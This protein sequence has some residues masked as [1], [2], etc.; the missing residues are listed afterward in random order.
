M[1]SARRIWRR[2]PPPRSRPVAQQQLETRR[3]ARARSE[4]HVINASRCTNA[5]AVIKNSFSHVLKRRRRECDL[6]RNRRRRVRESTQ[7]R[8][9]AISDNIWGQLSH[10]TDNTKTCFPNFL[11]C[12]YSPGAVK[13]HSGIGETVCNAC[14]VP[15]NLKQIY[16]PSADTCHARGNVC[17]Y[18]KYLAGVILP[19]SGFVAGQR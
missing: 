17:R 2:R 18:L 1:T 10:S 8:L 5:G 9:A 7:S 4:L 16:F 14:T 12:F 13:L 19:S 15:L 6:F 11:F 3:E